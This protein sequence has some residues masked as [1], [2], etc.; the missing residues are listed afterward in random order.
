MGAPYVSIKRLVDNSMAAMLAAIELYNKPQMTYRDEL[1]VMLVVNAWELALKGALRRSGRSIFHPKQRGEKYRSIGLDDALGRV[2]GQALWPAG[3][4]GPAVTANIK[5]LSEYRDRAIHLYNAQGL[6]AVI[7]P[8]LQQNVLNY[9]DF[10]L[11]K[12]RKDLADSVTWQ[13]LPLGATAPAD[14]VQFMRVDNNATMIAEVQDF[15]EELRRLMNAAEAN[16]GDVARIATIYDINLQSV[17]R[18]TSA[19]LVVAVS[20]TASG[21]VVIHKTDPNDTHPYNQ[22]ELLAR[23]NAKRSGRTLTTYDHQAVCWKDNLRDNPTLAWK[24]SNG[25]SHVWSGE[26]VSYLAS[27]SDAAYDAAR[28]EYKGFLQART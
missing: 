19:D 15:I 17:K 1:S 13:L 9:R 5:A 16:G 12:F 21:Q 2:G 4:D 18:V 10:M 14:V 28:T 3:I 11:A 23:V 22:Q 6:G 20:P 27:L 24:H 26:A 25:A 8:F 7:H